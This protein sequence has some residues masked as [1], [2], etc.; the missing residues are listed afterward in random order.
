MGFDTA[1]VGLLKSDLRGIETLIRPS[2]FN[3]LGEL[4]SDLRGIET[5]P[6]LCADNTIFC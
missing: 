6:E 3:L 4:K 5:S 1:T 2:C